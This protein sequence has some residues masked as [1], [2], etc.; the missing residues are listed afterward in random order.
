MV[1]FL[2][3]LLALSL[4][5]LIAFLL[6]SSFLFS[7]DLKRG[8]LFDKYRNDGSFLYRVESW[9]NVH[10]RGKGNRT[11]P[12]LILLHRAYASVHAWEPWVDEL[13]DKFR[14]ISFDLPC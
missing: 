11:G 1:R 10:I 3:S 9:A 12:P 2:G 4:A 13:G 6:G 14:L 5:L 7:S 8:D